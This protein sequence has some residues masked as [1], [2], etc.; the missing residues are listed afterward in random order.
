MAVPSNRSQPQVD[1]SISGY[2]TRVHWVVMGL[3]ALAMMTAYF[4]RQVISPSGAAIREEFKLSQEALG[5]IQS[6][7][8]AGYTLF[9][10]PGAF[11]GLW[12]GNR[13]A[14]AAMGI[15]STTCVL[16]AASSQ[17]VDGLY[18]AQF[19]LGIAQSVL[20]PCGL[21]VVADWCPMKSRGLM[22]AILGSSMQVG[23]ILCLLAAG[24]LLTDFFWQEVF[25]LFSIPSAIWSVFF[26][27]YF[28]NSPGEHPAVNALELQEI[29][30]PSFSNSA[31]AT[32]A[33]AT[34]TEKTAGKPP[35][36]FAQE[37]AGIAASRASPVMKH[38]TSVAM[39]MSRCPSVW[40]LAGQ[41]FF[42]GFGYAFLVTWLPTFLND[43]YG[44]DV[45]AA[46]WFSILP[47]AMAAAGSMLSGV[48]VDWLL[49]KT[50]NKWQSRILIACVSMAIC[51]L[52]SFFAQTAQSAAAA[53]GLIAVG[54]F[55][56]GAAGPS[57]WA[58][59]IDVSGRHNSIMSAVMNMTGNL[60]AWLSPLVVGFLMAGVKCKALDS[61][62][63][64]VL[65]ALISLSG[66]GM[67]FFIDPDDT[68]EGSPAA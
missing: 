63:I 29:R 24:K 30:T 68:I 58:A 38:V 4:A 15:L 2:P 44:I 33:S 11:F 42:R 27:L 45:K 53:V 57:V 12:F 37:P 34:G 8:F 7:F 51:G 62:V 46:S 49:R 22:S 28:R 19:C 59:S 35:A 36:E 26:I 54:T 25:F 21:K 20:V 31:E 47:L 14:L 17:S 50:G 56:L 13:I 40:L 60:G 6:A 39:K 55:F 65:F 43:V 61:S 18:W 64:F 66:A 9:Q 52:T 10:L 48:C 67:I 16:V 32:L 23:A 3:M 1:P 5:Q 41:Q